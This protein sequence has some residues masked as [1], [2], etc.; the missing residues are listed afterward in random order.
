MFQLDKSLEDW[1]GKLI[2]SNTMTESDVD[3]LESHLLDEIDELKG[4]NLT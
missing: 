1:K 2:N 3:E 4:K